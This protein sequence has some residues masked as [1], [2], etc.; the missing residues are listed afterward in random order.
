MHSSWVLHGA[1]VLSLVALV[2]KQGPS[3]RRPRLRRFKLPTMQCRLLGDRRF[4][5]MYLREPPPVSNRACASCV[6]RTTGIFAIRAFQAARSCVFATGILL[7]QRKYRYA[8][9][10]H[11]PTLT[12]TVESASSLAAP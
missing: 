4:T 5:N 10:D 8:V 1:C 3:E 7:Y 9:V 6:Q 2:F 11:H 12:A